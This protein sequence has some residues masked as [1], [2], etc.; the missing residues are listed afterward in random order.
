MFTSVGKETPASINSSGVAVGD[1]VAVPVGEAEAVAVDVAVADGEAE[2]GPEE[3][4]EPK[5]FVDAKIA[6]LPGVLEMRT[7]PPLFTPETLVVA[8]KPSA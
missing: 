6:K 2:A 8:A 1:A 4:G 5:I 7:F 3:T